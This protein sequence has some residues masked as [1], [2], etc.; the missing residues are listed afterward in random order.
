MDIIGCVLMFILIG[1]SNAGGTSGAGSNIPLLLIF[2]GLD[3][4]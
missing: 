3:M 2:Y 1:V 4:G